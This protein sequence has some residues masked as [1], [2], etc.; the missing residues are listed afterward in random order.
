MAAAGPQRPGSQSAGALKPQEPWG[1]YAGRDEVTLIGWAPVT[2]VNTAGTEQGGHAL[3]ESE[4]KVLSSAFA[5][6]EE[7]VQGSVGNWSAMPMFRCS[8]CCWQSD[9]ISTL[10]RN[11]HCYL[12][13]T[14]GSSFNP[15]AERR[16]IGAWRVPP[17]A[18]RVPGSH[19]GWLGWVA[20]GLFVTVSEDKA[21]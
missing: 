16:R 8:S 19:L 10:E 1:P 2:S 9:G 13:V 20:P 14:K 4:W 17:W 21:V 11:Y 5:K 12:L 7:H 6:R 3:G 18:H 15:K